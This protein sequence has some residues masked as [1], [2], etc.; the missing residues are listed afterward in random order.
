[1]KI[2]LTGASGFLG[3]IFN[4][5]WNQKHDVIGIGRNPSNAIQCDLAVSIPLLPHADLIVHAA[6]LAHRL[7]KNQVPDQEYFNVN[8]QGTSNLLKAVENSSCLPRLLVFISSVSVYGAESGSGIDESYPLLAKDAY[9]KSKIEAELLIREWGKKHN[10]PVVV[11][12]LPL[13]AG[14]DPPG[15]LGAMI[16]AIRSGYYFRIGKGLAQRSVVNAIDVANLIPCLPLQ[17]G[18]FN[19]TASW[20]PSIYEIDTLISKKFNKAV[21]IIP[22]SIAGLL[23]KVGDRFPYLPFNSRQLQKLTQ[24]LTFSDA[25]ARKTLHWNP[26]SKINI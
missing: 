17:S 15:N 21:K 8:K 10:V 20:H 18:I 1:M 16:S 11:L 19:L 23:A 26:E 4:T 22:G 2:L 7:K 13:I 24:S 6:G 3:K 14:P 12:R 9:G 25:L 5:A